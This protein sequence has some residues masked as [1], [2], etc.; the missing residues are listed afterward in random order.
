MGIPN[1]VTVELTAPVPELGER[2]VPGNTV[3]VA[4]LQAAGYTLPE[5]VPQRAARSV[6][7]PL[8][9]AVAQTP[10]SN[11]IPERGSAGQLVPA[12]E[13]ISEANSGA[14]LIQNLQVEQGLPV[15]PATIQTTEVPNGLQEVPGQTQEVA[16][17][18]DTLVTPPGGVSEVS[19]VSPSAIKENL[20]PASEVAPTSSQPSPAQEN[21][22]RVIDVEDEDAIEREAQKQSA[23]RPFV[24]TPTQ[25]EDRLITE[26]LPV[27]APDE[28]RP[29]I[30]TRIFGQKHTVDGRIQLTPEQRERARVF[31]GDVIRQAGLDAY[32]D[33]EQKRWIL[34]DNEPNEAAGRELLRLV[35]KAVA[36]HQYDRPFLS[37]LENSL[38]ARE[39]DSISRSPAF[40]EGL[41]YDLF[42][43]AQSHASWIGSQL[44]ALASRTK[45]SLEYVA[46]HAPRLLHKMYYDTWGGKE[47]SN[48]IGKIQDEAAKEAE[49]DIS[50]KAEKAAQKKAERQSTKAR[51]LAGNLDESV[52]QTEK[53]D[54]ATVVGQIERFS[55]IGDIWQDYKD[56]ITNKVRSA[57]A[58]KKPRR[59]PPLEPFS[60]DIQR[61]L[62]DAV[63]Q[64]VK[65]ADPTAASTA[66]QIESILR[67]PE[68]YREALAQ[69]KL[70]LLQNEARPKDEQLPQPA[71]DAALTAL[72]SLVAG[73]LPTNRLV[74]RMVKQLF[75]E[76][77]LNPSRM[78]A[79]RTD[80]LRARVIER[81]RQLFSSTEGVTTVRPDGTRE[82]ASY[83][84][85]IASNVSGIL[86]Q[87]VRD[88]RMTRE[89]RARSRDAREAYDNQRN[90]E[91]IISRYDR[92]QAPEGVDERAKNQVREAFEQQVKTPEES[93]A[94]IAKL[95]ALNVDRD[96]ATSLYDI[97]EKERKRIE[98][99]RARR[100]ASPRPEVEKKDRPKGLRPLIDAILNAPPELHKNPL[101]RARVIRD[102]LVQNGLSESVA[103]EAATMFDREL[104]ATFEQARK[105]A[106]ER[107]E[108]T[109]SPPVRRTIHEPKSLW[110]NIKKS[111]NAGLFDS[112]DALKKIAESHGWTVPDVSETDTIRRM[113]ERVQALE[114]VDEATR[115]AIAAN[116]AALDMAER[117][118]RAATLNEV[119]R[120]RRDIHAAWS[121]MTRPINFK[122]A[123]G[124]ANSAAAY[125]E[126]LTSNI[127]L[128]TA[129]FTKQ[130][131]DVAAQI[132][133]RIPYRVM[134]HAKMMLADDRANDRPT[135]FW[136]D[137]SYGLIKAYEDAA[138]STR[139]AAMKFAQG[140]RGAGVQRNVDGIMSQ[141]HAFDRLALRAK[142]THEKGGIT[143]HIKAWLMMV[144][145]IERL[146][147]S[148]AR[149]LDNVNGVM[150][151]SVEFRQAAI[152]ELRS[153]GMSPEEA[154]AK[155][156]NDIIGD[157]K[158]EMALSLS[159]ATQLLTDK[160]VESGGK[161]RGFLDLGD[162]AYN[163]FRARQ[164][165]RMKAEGI[166]ADNVSD[167]IETLKQTYGWNM[168]EETGPGSLVGGAAR[169]INKKVRGV[170]P[171]GA[172]GNAMANGINARFVGSGAQLAAESIA[173]AVLKIA[174]RDPK[175][176]DAF[177][178]G[179]V[180]PKTGLG[181]NAWFRTQKDRETQ[182]IA[183]AVGLMTW[184]VV[185]GLVASGLARVY[186][187]YPEDKE[188]K[189]LLI[190]QGVKP[191]C[192]VFNAGNGN[193]AVMGLTSGPATNFSMQFA[194][195]GLIQDAMDAV[196][197]RREKIVNDALDEGALPDSLPNL[198]AGDFVNAAAAGAYL[199]MMGGRTVSGATNAVYDP[200]IENLDVQ[201]KRFAAGQVSP[202][203]PFMPAYQQV[204]RA[205]D[206]RPD[207]KTAGFFDLVFYTGED[208]KN[209]L[210]DKMTDDRVNAIF[211]T[212]TGGS[213][214]ISRKADSQDDTKPYRI[215]GKINYRPSA[216]PRDEGVNVDGVWKVPTAEQLN[217]LRDVRGRLLKDYMEQLNENSDPELLEMRVKDLA[218]I[219]SDQAYDEVMKGKPQDPI[220]IDLYDEDLLS[221][222]QAQPSGQD[223]KTLEF[224]RS[225]AD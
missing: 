162:A 211:Q 24:E 140:M 151:E 39:P 104:Q 85:I 23:N 224:L 108:K 26:G 119:H 197:K 157:R 27:K 133:F 68:K 198:E 180:D 163:V 47:V 179:G 49:A 120:L 77:A 92:E 50:D 135:Q 94:F 149:A 196:Q 172:F 134:A 60:N 78:A 96:A 141:I 219:A 160:E 43:A 103:A 139:E 48:L 13:S 143:N 183:G 168:P 212:L 181:R 116:P 137:A 40:S 164:Y 126:H 84:D 206:R 225:L 45:E 218:S 37:A 93:G 54:I 169:F 44:A 201:L 31:A 64:R 171:I 215:F 114:A 98:M 174:G 175:M 111:V 51:E 36:E 3:R 136:E 132:M 155:V 170:I 17:T 82:F 199:A 167:R 146:S 184:P 159:R 75:A 194:A 122:S 130:P 148:Y 131:L 216:F 191:P 95:M 188:E 220:S 4:E 101:W 46:M 185:A 209:F 182:K 127:L 6:T 7:L 153:R 59:V 200:S 124:I 107:V 165:A 18:S 86:D 19:D 53:P 205:F 202:G 102:F 38:R 42:A 208:Q 158:A 90:A 69:V 67:N 22:G 106:L 186:M 5:V 173:K 203:I 12:P 15:Q 144:A 10:A 138:K 30:I 195:A 34:A 32:W 72:E 74:N 8:S 154:R 109:L 97:A 156:E 87:M 28:E 129:F 187:K 1:L 70:D 52:I 29:G 177:L 14:S 16:R 161:V 121:K 150:A 128:T 125:G 100:V 76:L 123:E 99:E 73:E 189:E 65:T 193:V 190:R 83:A 118:T 61:I 223:D 2:G 217:R 91:T 178:I 115:Q 192:V 210:G 112:A 105:K 222:T 55:R 11:Q 66:E 207:T 221:A 213:T 62:L 9:G 113:A 147:L 214:L 79:G 110:S 80:E 57:L 166:D 41:Q 142:R 71:V 63:K 145:G 204:E 88:A 89:E 21:V 117:E 81:A 33:A 56:D 176:A 20:I 152:E 25:R 58:P 35:E